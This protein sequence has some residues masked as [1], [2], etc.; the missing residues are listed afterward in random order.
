V[1]L[2]NLQW[3]QAQRADNRNYKAGQILQLHQNIAGFRR[4]DRVTV[5]TS[6]NHGVSVERMTGETASVPLD[7]AARFQIYE[8]RQIAL[9]AGDWIGSA[10]P[11]T[12]PNVVHAPGRRRM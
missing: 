10:L 8:S 2:K 9:T 12:F 6:D 4:G 11:A 7:M 5:K 3:T 1:Q